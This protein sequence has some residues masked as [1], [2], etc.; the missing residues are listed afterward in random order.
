MPSE[1]RACAYRVIRRVFEQDAYADRALHACAEGLS[2]RERSQAMRLSYGAIQRIGTLDPAIER[3]SARKLKTLDPPVLAALRLGLYE[4]LYSEAPAQ[5]AIVDDAVEIV[6]RA[7]SRGHGLVNAVLR[8]AAREGTAVLGELDD[9]TP[10]A[11]AIA[12]SHPQWL[13]EMWW[14]QLGAKRA[15]SLMAADNE[16]AQSALRVNTLR[17]DP[18]DVAAKLGL[19]QAGSR[20]LGVDLPEALVL[21]QALDLRAS[22]LW[23]QGAVL[24]QS[25]A[26]MLVSRVLDPQPGERVLDLCAAPGG[27]TSHLCALM[28]GEGSILAVERHPG[29]ARELRESL[30]RMGVSN[31]EVRRA[32]AQTLAF[33]G[34]R[35]DRVLLDAPCSGL[36]TLQGHPD[37]RWRAGPRRI[38]ELARL[39]CKILGVA[40]EAVRAGGT[41]VYSTCTISIAENERQIEHFL[42]S[43]AD[44]ASEPA[45][46][47]AA[48]PGLSPYL[49]T[50]PDRDHTAGFFIAKL[51]RR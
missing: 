31:V 6:K 24:A 33:E 3:L 47:A 40:A 25:R 51:R 50:L 23:R 44:F 49:S 39:Q 41:L 28:R 4:L 2:Q 42:D 46:P 11:A 29:R 17:A 45:A 12:H 27:K 16:P 36:G 19:P 48:K 8:R 35:F 34:Q 5:H 43:H 7:R 22:E 15:R 30:D 13:A 14:T 21:T 32:D 10:Q 20:L 1:A 38:S 9:S 26:A 37:L 18:A